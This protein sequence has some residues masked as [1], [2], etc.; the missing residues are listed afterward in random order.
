MNTA[1]FL[2]VGDY[3]DDHDRWYLDR[4]QNPYPEI[5]NPPERWYRSTISQIEDGTWEEY[6]AMPVE[7]RKPYEPNDGEQLKVW[8]NKKI[9]KYLKQNGVKIRAGN[10]TSFVVTEYWHDKI[11]KRFAPEYN[12]TFWVMPLE[13]AVRIAEKV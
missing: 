3:M 8:A 11:M 10:V 1:K 7:T 13:E 6:H 2:I 5:P 12:K 9:G 4:P